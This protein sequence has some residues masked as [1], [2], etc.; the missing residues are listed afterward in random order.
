M[1]K[2]RAFNLLREIIEDKHL[3]Y[4]FQFLGGFRL[5]F[6]QIKKSAGREVNNKFL[7][8]TLL[9]RLFVSLYFYKFDG[10]VGIRFQES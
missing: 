7:R 6:E 10:F 2:K 5:L 3:F 9:G 1:D 4:F 8:S